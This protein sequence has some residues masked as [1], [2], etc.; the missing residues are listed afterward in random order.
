MSKPRRY[1]ADY[2]S[3]E[4]GS[5][6]PMKTIAIFPTAAIE[7]HG[8]HLPVGTDTIIN[9]GHL[10]ALVAAAPDDIDFRILP[11]QEIGKSNEHLRHLGTLTLPATVLIEAWTEIGLSVARSG[12]R[13]MI[14]MNSHGG[15]EEIMGIVARELRVRASM[16]VVKCAWSRFG[17]PDGLFSDR[18][19]RYGIHGGDY[20]T[21]LM[22]HFRPDLVD[23]GKARDFVSRVEQDEKDFSYLKATGPFA[24]AWLAGDLNS[25]GTVGEANLATAEK[26]RA[27]C[28]FAVDR[29][30]ELLRDVERAPL[31]DAE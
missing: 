9:R 5:V 7:Q 1:W 18:E 26:G 13:K 22:L 25:A 23:M 24:Y 19:N 6:D 17:K 29:F 11:L 3:S 8:P 2:S 16:L 27:Q 12:V 30:V 14:F 15:N 4:F 10:D 21:S 31:M 28:D 20:E